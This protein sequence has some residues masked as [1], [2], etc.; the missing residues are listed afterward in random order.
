MSQAAVVNHSGSRESRVVGAV[1]IA[2]VLF[3]AVLA[4]INANAASLNATIVI[5]CEGVL[6]ATAIFLSLRQRSTLQVRWFVLIVG[7]ILVN[8]LNSI[9]SANFDPKFL[10]DVLIIPIFAL[11]GLVSSRDAIIRIIVRIQWVVLAVMVFEAVRPEDFGRL[12]GITSYYINTRGFQ[13]E[14]FWSKETSDLFVSAT[15]PG[16]RFLFSSLNIH[17]CSSVFLE[18]VSLGNYCVIVTMII[19]TMWERINRWQRSFLIVS[20]FVLLVGCDGR[21]ATVSI[22]LMVAV[23]FFAPVM[24]RYSNVL[25]MPVL[26]AVAAIAVVVFS[27][28]P[29]GDDFLSRTAGSIVDL[30]TMGATELLGFAGSYAYEVEDS[31]ISYLVCSQSLVGAGMIWLMIACALPQKDRPSITFSHAASLYVALNLLISY[32][33]FSIKTAG[34]LWFVYGA[35]RSNYSAAP[36]LAANSTAR[37][38]GRT[39]LSRPSPVKGMA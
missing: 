8:I 29:I 36:R 1:V 21:F 15:R 26:V 30:G 37:W 27:I 14:Q 19:V 7:L 17:R 34:L 28:S 32:S 4:V 9:G 5:G 39:T 10:R 35:I 31:G 6:D 25:Y 12:F 16:D 33:V 22:G 20:T 13:A 24:P 38:I 23:R 18:P 2:A 3:N 11:L